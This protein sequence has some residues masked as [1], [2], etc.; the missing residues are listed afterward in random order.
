MRKMKLKGAACM[1]GVCLL[2]GTASGWSIFPRRY[3]H[4]PVP[5]SLAPWRSFPLAQFSDFDNF[6]ND[7][8][9]I[10]DHHLW[11]L[12]LQYEDDRGRHQLRGSHQGHDAMGSSGNNADDPEKNRLSKLYQD[13]VE[14]SEHVQQEMDNV[15]EQLDHLSQ[16]SV[17]NGQRTCD[18][19]APKRSCN[20]HQNQ[21]T[22][23]AGEHVQARHDN[24][25]E[26]TTRDGCYTPSRSCSQCRNQPSQSSSQPV[27]ERHDN[28]NESPFY[29]DYPEPNH[30]QTNPTQ[31]QSNPTQRDPDSFQRQTNAAT[32]RHPYDRQRQAETSQ[33]QHDAGQRQVNP[34]QRQPHYR[35]HH[36]ETSQR[37]NDAS[38][39]Q[40]VN[41]DDDH[42]YR[43][44]PQRQ[45]HA[46]Q[47]HTHNQRH[48]E[49]NRRQFDDVHQP[50][51][52]EQPRSS[53]PKHNTRQFN[54][55]ENRQRDVK[56]QSSLQ[57]VMLIPTRGFD[58]RDLNIRHHG[59][60]IR[61]H[62]SRTC[63]G[64]RTC[65]TRE[66]ETSYKLPYEIERGSMKASI[67]GSNIVIKGRPV[68]S[69]EIEILVEEEPEDTLV[70][71]HNSFENLQE[72]WVLE[73][74]DAENG[75]FIETEAD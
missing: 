9:S 14:K 27:Y 45:H 34:T 44:T 32:H 73:D 33:R 24:P 3:H 5:C 19:C 66:M 53:F 54:S 62:A 55:D 42:Q 25:S 6:L 26:A 4:Q 30:H 40:A 56:S 60:S 31:H 58:P 63:D 28:P 61:V 70:G 23:C 51:Q 48:R 67:D 65:V 74:T 17:R 43:A 50:S 36:A 12:G 35:Q 37:Q 69:Q 13:S 71:N 52:Q 41:P 16:W 10:T 29:E 20:Q 21:R 59:N 38:Q 2:L 15:Q 1:A 8:P 75:V 72:H 57:E 18:S 46:T 47:R 68:E 49:P 64:D 22:R 7:W 39:R 11:P